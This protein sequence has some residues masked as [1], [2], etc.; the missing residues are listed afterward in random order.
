M[1][2][3]DL[4]QYK[5]ERIPPNE[6]WHAAIA[7]FLSVSLGDIYDN[8][9]IL[10]ECYSPYR[11]N[12]ADE[13]SYPNVILDYI[14]GFFHESI[15]AT[16]NPIKRIPNQP[17][18]ILGPPGIGKTTYLAHILKVLSKKTDIKIFPIFIDMRTYSDYSNLYQTVLERIDEILDKTSELRLFPLEASNADKLEIYAELFESNLHNRLLSFELNNWRE[19]LSDENFKQNLQNTIEELLKNRKLVLIKH[20]EYLREKR[21]LQVVF[22]IDNFDQN[23]ENNDINSFHQIVFS[24]AKDILIE[25]R[26]PVFLPMRNYTFQD[27]YDRYSFFEASRSRTKSLSSPIH[28]GVYSKRKDYIL[29]QIDNK[30]SFNIMEKTWEIPGTSLKERLGNVLQQIHDNQEIIALLEG[31]AGDDMRTYLE[32]ISY[33]LQ[34]GHLTIQNVTYKSFLKAIAYCNNKMF[35]PTDR[36]TRIINLYDNQEQEGYKNTLIKIRFLQYLKACG[37]PVN[38]ENIIQELRFLGYQ[39]NSV[40]FAAERFIKFG[41]IEQHPYYKKGVT[42]LTNIKFILTPIGS[43]YIDKLLFDANYFEVMCPSINITN[44]LKGHAETVLEQKEGHQKQK[45]LEE[46]VS[47]VIKCEEEEKKKAD[48]AA[49]NK[50]IYF[51]NT[52]KPIYDSIKYGY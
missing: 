5:D 45:S 44:S 1:R 49:I 37:G 33:A 2:L 46:M 28:E 39:E 3:Y 6:L 14:L 50:N 22:V 31:L 11:K 26:Q 43:Y 10:L 8:D 34:S 30:L 29:S 40:I 13:T 23:H 21:N 52:F 42:N 4:K 25:F 19:K 27:S 36:R 9:D 47:Y 41:L 24:L 20:I 16:G 17:Y 7:N 51:N 35:V 18:V 38:P 15:D 32:L 12:I 48:L